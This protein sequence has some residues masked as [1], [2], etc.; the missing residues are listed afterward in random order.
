MERGYT[1]V[2][3]IRWE[4]TTNSLDA[5]ATK[6]FGHLDGYSYGLVAERYDQPVGKCPG[7]AASL[8]VS[9]FS[10]EAEPHVLEWV[11]TSRG[12]G[13]ELACRASDPRWLGGCEKALRSF[14]IA[15]CL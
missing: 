1:Y 12:K 5:F 14:S 13:Y 4:K 15:S 11:T 8:K 2:V 7:K 6:A 3:T 9:A 10:T